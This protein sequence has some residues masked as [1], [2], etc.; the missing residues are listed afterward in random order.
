MTGNPVQPTE[1]WGDS[2]KQVI[3]ILHQ[4]FDARGTALAS[5]TRED[6]DHLFSAAQRLEPMLDSG[7]RAVDRH[8]LMNVLAAVRGYAEMLKEDIGA[9]F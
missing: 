9:E 7:G 1:G 2:M 5:Q 8:E 6:F 4:A 3:D